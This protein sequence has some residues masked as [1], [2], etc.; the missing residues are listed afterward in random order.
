MSL[1][2]QK[3]NWATDNSIE[4]YEKEKARL[5]RTSEYQIINLLSL[6]PKRTY[7]CHY[8]VVSYIL[9]VSFL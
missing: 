8:N 1:Q 9:Y 4:N 6:Q 5:K 2:C 3:H 7:K